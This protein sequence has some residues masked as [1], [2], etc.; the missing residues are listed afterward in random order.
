MEQT[1]SAASVATDFTNL[2]LVNV[3]EKQAVTKIRITKILPYIANLNPKF[4]IV[5][6]KTQKSLLRS[7]D[8]RIKWLTSGQLRIYSTVNQLR[9]FWTLPYRFTIVENVEYLKISSLDRR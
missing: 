2:Y 3:P 8:F 7:T 9:S 6:P 5:S 4:S 1:T